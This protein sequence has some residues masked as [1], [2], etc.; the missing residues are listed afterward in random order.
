MAIFHYISDSRY[1]LDGVIRYIRGRLKKGNDVRQTSKHY[2]NVSDYDGLYVSPE[3]A[4]MDMLL[5]K[6]ICSKEGGSQYKHFVLSLE[7]NELVGYLSRI[8]VEGLNRWDVFWDVAWAIQNITKCQL[9]YAVHT[10]TKNIHMHIIINPIRMDTYQKLN[11][12]Y[13]MFYVM[14]K[15]LNEILRRYRLCEIRGGQG[16]CRGENDQIVNIDDT[17][18]KWWNIYPT[19]IDYLI[20]EL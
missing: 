17:E 9:V 10:N 6:N 14:I 3:Q 20:P 11:I 18:T 1:T 4:A 15:T 16:F 2:G 5:F 12:N 7:E 13:Q 8:T 19:D